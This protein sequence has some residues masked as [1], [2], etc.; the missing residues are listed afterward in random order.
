MRKTLRKTALRFVILGMMCVVFSSCKDA[1]DT[2]VRESIKVTSD[3]MLE[4]QEAE[5][6][7]T[8]SAA[9]NIS[10]YVTEDDPEFHE[11]ELISI[12]EIIYEK[13][14][15]EEVTVCINDIT[16]KPDEMWDEITWEIFGDM[17]PTDS[18]NRYYDNYEEIVRNKKNPVFTL[19]QEDMVIRFDDYELSEYPGRKECKIPYYRILKYLNKNGMEALGMTKEDLIYSYFMEARELSM[20]FIGTYYAP[21]SD[22]IEIEGINY[23][24]FSY[25]DITTMDAFESLLKTRLSDGVIDDLLSG[26]HF[27]EVDGTLYI[28]DS[29]R[30]SDISVHSIEYDIDYKEGDSEGK[31]IAHICREG[32]DSDSGKRYLTGEVD[33]VEIPFVMTENGAV[34]TAFPHLT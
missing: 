31:I 11:H 29:A 26:G 5:P 32:Y 3:T 15:E 6:E 24:P 23:A 7:E 33:D 8:V 18:N 25:R 20:F 1:D 10:D 21:G 28:Q 13:A 4:K 22:M 9:F 14:G 16:D 17:L 34:F 30:G 19:E 12:P 27:A 2:S